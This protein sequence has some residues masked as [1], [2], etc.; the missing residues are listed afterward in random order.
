MS[1]MLVIYPKEVNSY[2]FNFVAYEIALVTFF[3]SFFVLGFIL[4]NL[5][6]MQS[7]EQMKNNSVDLDLESSE[8]LNET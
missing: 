3:I 6:V 4:N 2:L 1:L 7:K 8:I 5:I